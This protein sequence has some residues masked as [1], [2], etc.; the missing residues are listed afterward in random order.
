[1]VAQNMGRWSHARKR[2]SYLSSIPEVYGSR[3]EDTSPSAPLLAL[4]SSL[5]GTFLSLLDSEGPLAL[6]FSFLCCCF[7]SFDSWLSKVKK[8]F[9]RYKHLSVYTK[10]QLVHKQQPE[11]KLLSDNLV[12]TVI[13][14]HQITHKMF[15]SEA[16]ESLT[17]I[18][19]M[20]DLSQT[21][22]PHH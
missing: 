1:M 5:R 12:T 10:H 15:I 7:S 3:S 6:V 20:C 21:T 13:L 19:R 11:K 22:L 17:Q 4:R 9:C 14:M 8:L 2:P 16:P 18:S